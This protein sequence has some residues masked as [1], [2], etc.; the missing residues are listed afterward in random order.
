VFTVK[1]CSYSTPNTEAIQISDCVL[2]SV[3][4]S[5]IDIIMIMW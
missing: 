2:T 4:S 1:I 3:I 5:V